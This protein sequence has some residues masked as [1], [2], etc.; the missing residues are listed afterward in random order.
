MDN[1]FDVDGFVLGLLVVDVDAVDSFL[2]F[3]LNPPSQSLVLI[4]IETQKNVKIDELL[5]L[6]IMLAQ[7][8]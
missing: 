7:L 3:L 4:H 5:F 1:F 6:V 2:Q 8:E